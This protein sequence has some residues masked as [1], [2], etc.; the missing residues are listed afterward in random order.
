[1]KTEFVSAVILLLRVI[2][3]FGGT[4]TTLLVCKKINRFCTLVELS[5]GYCTHIAAENSLEVLK[6]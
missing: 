3:P 2:D 4:G 1:M 6:I 5:P